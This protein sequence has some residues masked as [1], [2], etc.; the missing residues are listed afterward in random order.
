MHAI[1]RLTDLGVLVYKNEKTLFILH[2]VLATI[3]WLALIV[4]TM[5]IAL[6]YMLALF[7]G[8]LFAQS[9]LIAWIK[10]NGVK[11]SAEQF[12]DLH[13][14][15]T[16]CCQ[17]LGVTPY[18]DAYLVN[19]GGVLNAFA[20]RFLGRNFVVLYSN[21]VDAMA[22]NPE[23][24]NFYI[25]HELGHI[26][27]K[28]LQWGPFIL[29]AS[30]LPL[31]G[32]AYSRACEYTCDQFGRACCDE[33]QPALQGLVA[34][35]VGEKRWAMLSVPAYLEQTKETSGFWMSFHELVADY[36]WLVKRAARL[37]N[38][39]YS[40]PARNPFAWVFAL[41]VPRFGLGGGMAG[42]LMMV[43][44]IGILA[45]ISIPAYQDYV[46]RAKQAQA[47]SAQ[48]PSPLESND[49]PPTQSSNIPNNPF[50]SQPRDKVAPSEF[51]D[52]PATSRSIED[53]ILA[54]ANEV[55]RNG[56][57]MVD[58]DTRLDGAVAGPGLRFTF[59]Y[60]LPNIESTQVAPGVFD[61]TFAPTVKNSACASSQL[62]PF[63]DNNVSVIYDYRGKDGSRIGVV[64]VNR[65]K[66]GSK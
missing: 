45:A 23:A 3:F 15:Y 54:A 58:A 8:Y 2:S 27:R 38:P 52:R 57:K 5:G 34:L 39:T 16:R 62:K 19:G 49:L 17:T 21:V 29:P 66:C 61:T 55:T 48:I 6:L 35:A 60:T 12:S 36:P 44:V 32:A 43:A 42:L 31:L 56:P 25:G 7:I 20:T 51:N 28:H 47:Q 10:G 64:E 13:E 24:I 41:F 59:L 18:P 53:E 40:S 50:D 30:I 4:G 9:A 33:P 46:N 22:D 65:I 11:I 26:Q 1:N 37:D 14:R 63:F